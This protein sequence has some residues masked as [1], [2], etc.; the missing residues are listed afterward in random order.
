VSTRRDG[1]VP[2][3]KEGR[4]GTL[5]RYA[6][7]YNDPPPVEHPDFLWCCW[8]YNAEHAALKFAESSA[9]EGFVMTGE[10]KRVYQ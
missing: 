5:Y 2:V 3:T 9:L 7:A 8:A 4:H 1:R 10:P 6:T